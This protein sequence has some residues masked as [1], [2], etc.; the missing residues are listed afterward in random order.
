[1]LSFALFCSTPWPV[2]YITP[3]LTIAS[4]GASTT[5][6]APSKDHGPADAAGHARDPAAFDFE[7][8]LDHDNLGTNLH[9]ERI[10][11]TVRG[12]PGG[13]HGL[14]GEPEEEAQLTLTFYRAVPPLIPRHTNFPG[15]TSQPTN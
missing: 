11:P 6:G 5:G 10:E 1:M 13:P 15:G 8:V 7:V 2:A 9:R 12:D 3:K 4:A 14:R